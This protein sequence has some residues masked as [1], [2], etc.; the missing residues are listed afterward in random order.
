M[1]LGTVPKLE[2]PAAGLAKVLE[3]L[4][5]KQQA[6]LAERDQIKRNTRW[7]T[8]LDQEKLARI[9][10]ELRHLG[11]KLATGLTAY[12]AVSQRIAKLQTVDVTV[13]GRLHAGVLLAI[14][15]Q[16]FRIR[17]EMPGPLK[18]RLNEAGVP[19]CEG[20]G[21]EVRLLSQV[22]EVRAVRSKEGP[23]R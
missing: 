21:G 15:P 17:E 14:G 7:L 2:S 13:R 10:S 5:A 8:S 3:Q 1:V 12:E 11:G 18:V 23:A 6:L 19:V 22:G 9:E 16:V 4:T 20:S